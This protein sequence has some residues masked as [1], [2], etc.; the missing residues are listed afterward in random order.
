[1]ATNDYI[2]T[3]GNALKA[4]VTAQDAIKAEAEKIRAEVAAS[5]VGEPARTRGADNGSVPPVEHGPQ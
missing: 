1:M 2:T 3:L 4:Y 5:T